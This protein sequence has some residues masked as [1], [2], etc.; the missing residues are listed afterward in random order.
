MDQRPAV[1]NSASV[2]VSDDVTYIYRQLDRPGT[3]WELTALDV[4]TG[5]ELWSRLTPRVTNASEPLPVDRG[6]VV[7]VSDGLELLR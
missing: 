6:L 5:V 1:E 3:S 4:I 2:L 7:P